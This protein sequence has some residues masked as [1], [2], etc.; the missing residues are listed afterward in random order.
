MFLPTAKQ[1][2]PCPVGTAEELTRVVE[3][4]PVLGFSPQE[5]AAQATTGT[6]VLGVQCGFPGV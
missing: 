3:V 5:L 4:Q 6:E 2:Q 1:N